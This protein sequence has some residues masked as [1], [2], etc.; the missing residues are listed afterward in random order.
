[1]HTGKS[2][3]GRGLPC[4]HSILHPAAQILKA[5]GG[6][7]ASTA[8]CGAMAVWKVFLL[9]VRWDNPIYVHI[10]KSPWSQSH[11]G[12]SNQLQ[13]RPAMAFSWHYGDADRR[14]RGLYNVC[15]HSPEG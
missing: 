4:A 13:S 15:E 2:V 6:Q 8:V 10:V 9:S 1:V 5:L 12:Q 11:S 7:L 3:R 14:T